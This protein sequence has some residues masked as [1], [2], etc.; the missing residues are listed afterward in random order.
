MDRDLWR[1]SQYDPLLTVTEPES[2]TGAQAP[3]ELYYALLK[4]A[5]SVH[6]D[7]I[8]ANVLRNLMFSTS[9]VV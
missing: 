3:G 6:A 9:I 2:D 1:A 7:P 5:L 4:L 8:A